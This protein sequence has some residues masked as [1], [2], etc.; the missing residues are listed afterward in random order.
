MPSFSALPLT[1]TNDSP[2][3]RLAEDVGLGDPYPALGAAAPTLTSR[4]SAQHEVARLRCSASPWRPTLRG[5]RR[6]G[7]RPGLVVPPTPWRRRWPP[8]PI[9]Q[10][11][12]PRARAGAHVRRPI[13]EDAPRSTG[14]HYAST[15]AALSPRSRAASTPSAWWDHTARPAGVAG[16]GPRAPSR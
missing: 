7:R 15:L 12:V 5:A 11:R 13:S 9:R 1:V 6:S 3:C 16:S 14:G 4:P 8:W 10:D 2:T